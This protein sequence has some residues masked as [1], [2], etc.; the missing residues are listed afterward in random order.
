[1]CE[2]VELMYV[3]ERTFTQLPSNV[4]FIRP[5]LASGSTFINKWRFEGCR[6]IKGEPA[7]EQTTKQIESWEM[8]F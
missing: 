7:R 3:K 2:P 4:E 6:P 8:Q 1:M 5:A